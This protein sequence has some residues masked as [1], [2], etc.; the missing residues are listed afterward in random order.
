MAHPI[1]SFRFC[2]RCGASG[3]SPASERSLLCPRCGF[4]YF[5]NAAAAVAALVF[6]REGRLLVTRRRLPP[7][8]GML[9]LP[10]GFVDPGENAEEALRRELLEELGMEVNRMVY[11][12]SHP[13]E[14]P[15]SG[16]TVFTADLAFRAYPVSLDKL[17]PADD[18]SAYEWIDPT[19]VNPEEIPAPSIRHFI[20]TVAP[21][22]Y[23][24]NGQN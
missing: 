9:D 5:V 15:F 4:H 18:I 6:N 23:S 13:N 8:A 14:Y 12:T 19:T 22:E 11:L 3:F 21:D 10:G 16:I 1:D 2:P 24:R 20:L 17:T 7:G